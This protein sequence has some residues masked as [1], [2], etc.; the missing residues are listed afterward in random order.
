MLLWHFI[1]DGNLL[2]L[3]VLHGPSAVMWLTERSINF[4]RFIRYKYQLGSDYLAKILIDLNLTVFLMDWDMQFTTSAETQQIV[5]DCAII[6]RRG[7]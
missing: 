6:I 1:V 5:R 7:G 3:L 2:I 4:F